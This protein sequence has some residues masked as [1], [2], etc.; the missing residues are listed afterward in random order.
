MIAIII[1]LQV[2]T[3]LCMNKRG[4]SLKRRSTTMRD[5]AGVILGS[6][7]DWILAFLV[8]S[9]I[10]HTGKQSIVECHIPLRGL[11]STSL[12]MV[13]RYSGT[14]NS[15][16]PGGTPTSGYGECEHTNISFKYYFVDTYDGIE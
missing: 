15:E 8:D 7:E 13:N 11:Q 4:H 14:E 3:N 16:R 5:S 1:F 2:Q 12:W 9:L 10:K 6:R